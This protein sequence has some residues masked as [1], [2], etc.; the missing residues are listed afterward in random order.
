MT[1]KHSPNKPKVAWVGNTPVTPITPKEQRELAKR[2]RKR[3]D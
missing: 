2:V 3:Q 1:K